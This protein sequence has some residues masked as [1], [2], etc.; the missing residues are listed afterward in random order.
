[1]DILGEFT[2]LFTHLPFGQS[3]GRGYRIVVL[4][5]VSFQVWFLALYIWTDGESAR[6]NILR[7]VLD[8]TIIRADESKLLMRK[9]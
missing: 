8:R 6:A 9:M 7:Y 5:W 4:G 3:F 2:F 1:M